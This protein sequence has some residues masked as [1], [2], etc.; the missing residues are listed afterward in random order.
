MIPI[1]PTKFRDHREGATIYLGSSSLGSTPTTLKEL[2][3]KTHKFRIVKEGFRSVEITTNLTAKAPI[4]IST[5]LLSLRY[6][7]AVTK[8]RN[9]INQRN[10][11][12]RLALASLETALAERPN[13]EDALKL[14]SGLEPALNSLDQREAEEK[15]KAEVA[16]RIGNVAQAFE[17]STI[18][19]PQSE[20]FETHQWEFQS[21]FATVRAALLRALPACST[22]WKVEG[23]QEFG[24]E[25]TVFSCKPQGISLPGKQCVV[26]AAQ[27]DSDRVYVYAKFWDYILSNK[28]TL[29]LFRGVTPN[30]VI[31]I[32]RRFFSAAQAA[33][34]DQ[35]RRDIAEDLH[36]RLQN[37]LR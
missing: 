22:T 31:P 33:G 21:N 35:R 6:I 8:A 19:I 16:A 10:P 24:P 13:D 3:P 1:S 11:N 9:E 34:I 36:T 5:D 14:K 23:E 26:L 37:A 15:R 2:Q 29:S 12:Y 7:E 27:V 25:T 30:S 20:L 4:S 18:N 32:H 17:Q 28:V